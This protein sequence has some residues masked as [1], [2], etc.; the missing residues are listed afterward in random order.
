[1]NKEDLEHERKM[2]EYDEQIKDIDK[3]L[4]ELEKEEAEYKEN[5]I[6]KEK[7]DQSEEA[8]NTIKECVDELLEI[9]DLKESKENDTENYNN[10]LLTIVSWFN[11]LKREKNNSKEY[12]EAID[13]IK[14]VGNKHEILNQWCNNLI[15][16]DIKENRSL[17]L[18]GLE[19]N[20]SESNVLKINDNISIEVD[21][22][23]VKEFIEK[24]EIINNKKID[25]KVIID[26]KTYNFV[27]EFKDGIISYSKDETCPYYVNVETWS[28]DD[29][30]YI[31][32]FGIMEKN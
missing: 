22:E 26:D 12:T 8:I 16:S 25:Y 18:N 5:K 30:Q 1:M 10:R 15:D 24:H 17:F 6:V 23:Q 31:I 19:L 20:I 28:K 29:G 32:K 3:Q 2:K 4:E 11:Y 13:L 21:S 7:V 14:S 27:L 9:D